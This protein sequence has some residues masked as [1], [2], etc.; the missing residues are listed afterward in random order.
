MINYNWSSA[1]QRDLNVVLGLAW[2]VVYTITLLLVIAVSYN[3][4]IG[5]HDG[6]NLGIVALLT[7]MFLSGIFSNS[8][9]RKTEELEANNTIDNSKNEVSNKK[10]KPNILLIIFLAEFLL[11]SVALLYGNIAQLIH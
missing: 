2:L 11:F 9:K 3:Q 4:F 7:Q 6:D 1:D 5:Y 10:T 8:N